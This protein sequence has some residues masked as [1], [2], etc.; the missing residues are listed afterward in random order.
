MAVFLLLAFLIAAGAA[1]AFWIMA[2]HNRA[3][4][5]GIFSPRLALGS[6]FNADGRRYF[7]RFIQICAA[8]VVV[9]LLAILLL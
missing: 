4:G 9:V 7:R 1:I 5:V 3:P 8:W 2:L 6:G